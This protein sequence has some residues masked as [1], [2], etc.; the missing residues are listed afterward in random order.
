MNTY[1][2][3]LSLQEP[4][5]IIMMTNNIEINKTYSGEKNEGAH[6]QMKISTNVLKLEIRKG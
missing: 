1:S 5:P 6:Q 4:H 2:F 3:S